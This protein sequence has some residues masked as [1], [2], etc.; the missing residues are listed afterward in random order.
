MELKLRNKTDKT[1]DIEFVGE[2]ETLLNV[3]KVRLLSDPKVETATFVTEHPTL[4][5]PRL[6]VYMRSGRPEPAI[7]AA[8]AALRKELDGLEDAFLKALQ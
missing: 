3:L 2:R 4:A 5:H 8:A 1:I 7:K 6:V